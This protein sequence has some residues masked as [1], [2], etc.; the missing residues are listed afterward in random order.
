MPRASS[1]GDLGDRLLRAAYD[2]S[3]RSARR[4]R[5]HTPGGSLHA[6]GPAARRADERGMARRDLEHHAGRRS[7]ARA[8]SRADRLAVSTTSS[9]C[10]S[11][12]HGGSH[13][14]PRGRGDRGRQRGTRAHEALLGESPEA[15]A[16][17]LHAVQ[18]HDRRSARKAP[19]VDVQPHATFSGRSHRAAALDVSTPM[20]RRALAPRC[21]GL[22]CSG[23]SRTSSS[24]RAGRRLARL[25]RV[26]RAL[27]SP[28]WFSLP[29]AAHA[30]VLGRC[31][32]GPAGWSCSPSPR[33]PGRSSCSALRRSGSRRRSRASSSPPRRCSSPSS[34][35]RSTR[36][37]ARPASRLAG[38]V[39][40]LGGVALLARRRR[41]HWL[42]RRGHRRARGPRNRARLRVLGASS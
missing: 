32:T 38:L 1:A 25:G 33:W 40:G 2:R 23:G 13:P 34:R 6:P 29:L 9:T 27:G 41:R 20:S 16:V 36:R 14:S 15:P 31:A 8:R 11:I 28:R 37:R 18:A 4:A 7:C 39:V 12:D 17:R 42:R 26:C 5:G 30:G 3:A 35:S 22:R 21:R 19:L 10:C 24:P